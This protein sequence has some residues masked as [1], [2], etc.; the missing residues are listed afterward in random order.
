MIIHRKIQE[1]IES[2][3]FESDKKKPAIVIYGPRQSGKTT[4]VKEILKNHESGSVFYDCDLLDT[5]KLF[6]YENAG[7]LRNVLY[8]VKLLVLDEAQKI[9]DIGMVIKIIVDTIPE[10][11]VIATGSSS[12]DLSNSLNEPLTGRKYEFRLMPFGFEELDSGPNIVERSALMKK[13]LRFGGYPE[14]ALAGEAGAERK[15]KELAGSY[16]FKDIFTFQELRKPEVLTRLVQLLAHQIGNEVSFQELSRTLGVDQTVVQKYL[17][18]LEQSF[19]V[20]RLGAFRRNLRSEVVKTRKIYFWDLGIRNALVGDFRPLD[21]RPDLG[22]L[23]ENFCVAERGKRAINQDSELNCYFWRTY[24]NKEVD[25]LEE[26]GGEIEAFEFKWNA[27]AKY[28]VPTEFVE[29]YKPK[30]FSVI[31]SDNF[32]DFLLS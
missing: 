29:T 15:L 12:F 16:L 25:Y 2:R 13:M 11:Q 1:K 31:N 10:T 21:G 14:A 5:Q 18:L 27:E 7:Q 26:K 24:G 4:L 17:F 19:I 22:A 23:W 6:S 28:K 30:K 8:G 9:K 32:S 20:F 3:L